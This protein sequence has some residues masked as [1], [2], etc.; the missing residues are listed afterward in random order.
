LAFAGVLEVINESLYG[1]DSR[2]NN[3]RARTDVQGIRASIDSQRPPR[4]DLF[5]EAEA[6]DFCRW[7]I[8]YSSERFPMLSGDPNPIGPSPDVAMID[9]DG[10]RWMT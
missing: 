3:A 2:F 6:L 1:H 10:F 9:A 8:Q 4:F 5:T 7:L